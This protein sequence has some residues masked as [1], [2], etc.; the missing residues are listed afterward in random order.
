MGRAL[1]KFSRV[2]KCDLV[3]VNRAVADILGSLR[4]TRELT[5][6]W[7]QRGSKTAQTPGKTRVW[8][9]SESKTSQ[10]HS[11]SCPICKTSI[12]GS[13]PGGASNLL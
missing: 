4:A 1:S 11:F 3:D 10:L 13:N 5:K 2:R 6:T 8:Q 12:P 7:V 9:I